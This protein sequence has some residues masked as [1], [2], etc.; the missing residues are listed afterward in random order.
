MVDNVFEVPK[1]EAIAREGI[2]V[3]IH[4]ATLD[5]FGCYSAQDFVDCIVRIHANLKQDVELNGT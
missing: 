2:A 1:G 5:R 3:I 4:P